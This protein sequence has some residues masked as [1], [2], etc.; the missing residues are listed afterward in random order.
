M[1]NRLDRLV[2]DM[3]VGTSLAVEQGVDKQQD[4]MVVSMGLDT[5]VE[6]GEEAT[7]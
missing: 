1:D 6:E 5:L 7:S 2:V 4:M 3:A